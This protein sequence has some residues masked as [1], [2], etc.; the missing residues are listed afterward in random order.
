VVVGPEELQGVTAYFDDRLLCPQLGTRRNLIRLRQ[1][2]RRVAVAQFIA[3]GAGTNLAQIIQRVNTPVAVGPGDANFALF[4]VNVNVG[5]RLLFGSK[6]VGC[7][8]C[9]LK[10]D[11]LPR[12]DGE[13]KWPDDRRRQTVDRRN[14]LL[15]GG[16]RSVVSGQNSCY[17]M[18]R[19][20]NPMLLP[21]KQ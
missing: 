17:N 9:L 20:E 15:P 10:A 5:G 13:N 6:R 4:E 8:L 19:F 2:Q 7:H 18:A 12:L 14:P 1:A 11:I 3:H 21:M 16:Q